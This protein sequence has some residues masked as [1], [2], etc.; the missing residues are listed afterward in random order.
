MGRLGRA[1]EGAEGG[2]GVMGRKK[3][4]QAAEPGSAA[5]EARNFLLKKCSIR[6]STSVTFVLN[7]RYKRSS[8]SSANLS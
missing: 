2:S 7:P 3:K 1:K 5:A 4:T 6:A 8:D